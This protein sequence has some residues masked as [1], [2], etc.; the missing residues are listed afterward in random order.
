MFLAKIDPNKFSC[1]EKAA[2]QPSAG[3]VF[4][5]L[6]DDISQL[7]AGKQ[8]QPEAGKQWQSM[9]GER[10]VCELFYEEK[11]YWSKQKKS[12]KSYEEIM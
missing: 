7:E 11:K 8:S 12:L 1:L 2:H 3:T 4:R 9:A 10:T 6:D 5:P